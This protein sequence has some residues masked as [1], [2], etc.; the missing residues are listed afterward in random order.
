MAVASLVRRGAVCIFRFHVDAGPHVE[1]LG[2][3]TS[4]YLVGVTVRL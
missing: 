4:G 1:V 3:S 2:D